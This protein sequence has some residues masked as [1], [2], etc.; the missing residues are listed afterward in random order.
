MANIKSAQK[1]IKISKRNEISNRKYKSMVKTYIKKYHLLI[2]KYKE[3]PNNENLILIKEANNI[4]FS[5][6]D[7]AVKK[8]VIHKN[9]ANRKKSQISKALKNL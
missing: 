5:K 4:V 2:N 7:K 6:I 8:N 1:R 9:T 3:T